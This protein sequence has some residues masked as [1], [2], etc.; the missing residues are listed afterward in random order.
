MKVQF[1]EG[2]S[3]LLLVLGIL[4]SVA[5][6]FEAAQWTDGMPLLQWAVI[7]G[8]I[9]GLAGAKSKF[10]GWFMHASAGYMG[11]FWTVFLAGTLLS[12]KLSWYER[13]DELRGRYVAWFW[14]AVLGN[15]NS[16]N[17]IFLMECLLTIFLISYAAAW[18]AY[19]KHRTS[20][21]I[22][23]AGIMLVVNIYNA[24]GSHGV[25][26]FIYLLCALLFAVR[27]HLTT[28][29]DW[30]QRARIGYNRLVGVDF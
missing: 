4:L 2:W 15:T 20:A 21:V 8:V 22:L 24:Q 9:W 17:I 11:L 27:A 23:P 3:S 5:W 16:D 10:P 28:E 29:E 19:R 7:F 30:W 1:R 18:F 25:Y 13:V 14:K 26:L 12:D 6:S